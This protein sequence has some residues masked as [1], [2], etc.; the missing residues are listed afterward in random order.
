MDED[1]LTQLIMELRRSADDSLAG[2]KIAT[3]EEP[4]NHYVCTKCHKFP[5]IKFCKNRKD[6]KLTCSCFN[7]KKISIEELFKI[8]N[9]RGVNFLSETNLSVDVENYCI[10]NEHYKKF[11]GFSKFFLNN[12]CEDCFNYKNEINNND[13]IR[14]DEIK[15][16]EKKIS[17]IIENLNDNKDI[18]EEISEEISNNSKSYK[19][20]QNIDKYL[21]KEEEIRFKEL[22]DVIINDYKN[23]P[24]FSHFFNIKNLLYFFNIG[25]KLTEKDENI[26]NDNFIEKNEPIIIEYINNVSNKTKLFSK[27]FV[28]NNEKKCKIE[29][30]GKKLDLIEKYEFK[31]TERKVRVKLFINKNVSEIN[32]YKMFSNCPNLIYINGISK[33]KKI[34]NI[35]KIFYN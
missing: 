8:I 18:S 1:T 24:N 25:N 21:L 28:K 32:M 13:I 3:I 14:F 22:I 35:N 4:R 33:L 26:I 12:Y 15:I 31:T 16:E 10:C 7:N 34:V 9:K 5:F 30:E 17:K 20:F 11:K 2:L 27:I 6:V 19:L 23:Y 29:I